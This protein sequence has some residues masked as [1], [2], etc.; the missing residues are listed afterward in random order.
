MK[1]P[2]SLA[3]PLALILWVALPAAGAEDKSS[4]ARVALI[5]G[6]GDYK[7]AP[8]KNPVNDARSV[9]RALKGLGF[10]VLLEENVSHQG[11]MQALRKFADRLRDTGGVGLFY[12]AGHGMQVKGSNYLIPVDSAIQTEDEVRYMALDANQVLD[13]MEQAGNRLNI[14]ILDACRDN[15]FARSFRSKQGG[16]AQ[17]DAPSGMLIAF[18][19]APGSVAYDGDGDNGVYTKHL[20]RT[21]TIP[22]LPV[23]LVLK[24]V[25]EQVARD[26]DQKQIPWES[27]SLLGDFYFNAAAAPAVAPQAIAPSGQLDPATMELAFWNSVKD[28]GAAEEYAAYLQTYPNGR[29]AALAQARMRSAQPQPAKP[30]PLTQVAVA[31]PAAVLQAATV[32][33]KVGDSWTY[34][35]LDGRKRQVDLVAVSVTGVKGDRIQEAVSRVGVRHVGVTRNFPGGFDPEAALQ[36]ASLPGRYSLVEF[37]PYTPAD[38]PQPG[39]KWPS[40]ER[41]VTLNT[42]PPKKVRMPMTLRVV[43]MET[44]TVPA[45]QFNAARVEARG[46]A[47]GSGEEIVLTYWFSPDVRRAIKISRLETF[48]SSSKTYEETFELAGFNQTR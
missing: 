3:L 33:A 41:E 9:A 16:L 27:S 46:K 13:K 36:E 48:A 22:G 31:A 38:V 18:A 39:T 11:F 15:P 28:S 34:S 25:R 47:A 17:M 44:V 32:R 40:I 7:S 43:A 37:S 8:L 5:V 45:G 1:V 35:L 21:L 6:N 42:D 2:W 30:A 29:F 24:R 19:T 26:T 20:L 23:E 12:Y 10:E 4:D 14:V